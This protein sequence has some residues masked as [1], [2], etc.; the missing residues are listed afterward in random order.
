MLYNIVMVFA[1]HQDESAIGIHMSTPPILNP[2]LPPSPP[3]PSRLSQSTSFAPCME[4]TLD[5]YFTYSK[6][7]LSLA[8]NGGIHRQVLVLFHLKELDESLSFLMKISAPRAHLTIPSLNHYIFPRCPRAR[9]PAFL[10]VVM[11]LFLF[12]SSLHN[13]VLTPYSI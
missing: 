5:I 1:I 4:L 9:A 8:S 13:S 2:L 3:Y 10:K 7:A 11:L 12:N 6:V